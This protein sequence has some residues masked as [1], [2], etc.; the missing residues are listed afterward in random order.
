MDCEESSYVST[1]VD[2]PFLNSTIGDRLQYHAVATPNKTAFVI[3]AF[4]GERDEITSLEI[5]ELSLAFAK[6]LVQLGLCKGDTV[7]L[8]FGNNRNWLIATFGCQMMGAVPVYFNCRFEDGRDALPILKFPENCSAI[9]MESIDEKHVKFI[10]NIVDTFNKADGKLFVSSIVLPTLRF[11]I[12]S[13]FKGTRPIIN[14]FSFVLSLG[15]TF[16]ETKLPDINPDDVA[17][18]LKTS[19]TTGLPKYIG[20]SHIQLLHYGEGSVMAYGM[21]STD[22][23]YNDRLF[24]WL[25]G[26]PVVYLVSGSTHVTGSVIVN[27]SFAEAC[28]FMIRVTESEKCTVTKLLPVTIFEL[29][30]RKNIN[31][32]HRV[33]TTSALPVPAKCAEVVGRFSDEFICNYGSSEMNFVCFKRVTE[34][35]DF[36]DYCTG[37]P[38]PGFEMKI[39]DKSGK[40][41]GRNQEGELLI[42]NKRAFSGYFK[43]PKQNEEAFDPDGWFKTDDLALIDSNGDFII[44]G[45]CSDLILCYGAPIAPSP[46][47]HE[48][49]RHPDVSEVCVVRISDPISFQ[50]PCVCV[51]VKTGA[52]LSVKDLEEFGLKNC[53]EPFFAMIRKYVILDNLPKTIDRKSVV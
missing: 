52:T 1:P 40:I 6:G 50:R 10:E 21:K 19:G 44:K 17:I 33:I 41:L 14:D 38:I 46:I 32:R 18:Y 24:Q 15:S 16:K 3:C 13:G 5:Y 7:G 20:K 27:Q 2:T 48:I 35:S 8:S 23:F 25:G 9:I 31:Y 28:D 49:Q 29:L 12:S 26:F 37:K 34:A 4:N 47:E 22:I 42:R 36:S 39:V 43:S 51:V 30:T 53:I 45:R 11:V